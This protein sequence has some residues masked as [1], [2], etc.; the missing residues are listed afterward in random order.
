M[1]KTAPL[2]LVIF[3]AACGASQHQINISGSQNI[4]EEV[5]ESLPETRPDWYINPPDSDGKYDYFVGHSARF[6]TEAAARDEAMNNAVKQFVRFCGVEV[7]IFD[8]YLRETTGKTSGVLAGILSNKEHEQQKAEAFVTSIRP[9]E[10]YLRKIRT[11]HNET[12]ISS[13][14]KVSVLVRV[15]V[16]EKSRV[17]AYVEKKKKEKKVEKKLSIKANFL[18][19][20][21]GVPKQMYDG[22]TLRS[23]VDFYSIYFRPEQDCYVYIYQVDSTGAVYQLFPNLTY[24]SNWNPVKKDKSYMVPDKEQRFYLDNVTG[25]ERLYLLA[26][27]EPATELENL[28]A[29]LNAANETQKKSI[30]DQIKENLTSRGVAG[31]APGESH[32][33]TAKS[34]EAFDVIG[35]NLESTKTGFVYM[36]SFMHK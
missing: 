4:R 36:L 31:T 10:W 25:E 2:V 7:G 13:G 33:V 9:K 24:S 15:P 11:Y 16:E 27:R 14:W 12:P 26:S 34:G 21:N 35:K 17:Q 19:E 28:F 22:M 20:E 29:K 30:Q 3:L 6:S 1:K 18:Y 32:K 23:N 5:V 8:E